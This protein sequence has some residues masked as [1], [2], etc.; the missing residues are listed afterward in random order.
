MDLAA[1]PES[2][3]A[4]FERAQV[5]VGTSL[6]IDADEHLVRGAFFD[7]VEGQARFVAG[8][9]V[10]STA[11]PPIGDLSVAVREVMAL[12]EAQT[13]FPLQPE[14]EHDTVPRAVTL[15]GQPA[16]PIRVAIV[17]TGAH[18][19]TT[20][21]AAVARSTHSIVYVLDAEIRTED[22]VM[23]ATLLENR[24]R[25]F[26]PHVVVLL[27]GDRAQAEWAS[28]VGTL[29]NMLADGTI[30]QMI[31]LA[32]DDFQQ[33]VIQTLGDAP[34][35]TGL[36]P[37]Q[38]ETHE[39]AIALETELSGMYQER[40]R[41]VPNPGLSGNWAYVS[42][43]RAGDLST[44][45][46]ARRLEKSAASVDISSGTTI[47]WSNVHTGGSLCRPDLDLYTHIRGIFGPR[48]EF[49]RALL[50]FELSGEELAN[51]VLNRASRPR[52]VAATPRDELIES[53]LASAIVSHAWEDMANI[54]SEQIEVLI[55]GPA[56]CCDAHPALGVLALLNGVQPTPLGGVVEVHLD[57]DGLLVAAGAVGESAPAVAADVIEHDVLAPVA[58][59]IVVEGE[60]VEGQLA[61]SG[62]LT[63]DDG[64]SVEFEVP[65]GTLRRLDFADGDSGSLW[66]TCEPGFAV[67]GSNPGERM[68]FGQSVPL[69][70]GEVGIIIDARGR[71]L[72]VEGES[73]AISRE[74][75]Q[76]WYAE[77]GI[78]L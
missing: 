72:E 61:V 75:V 62:R 34:N 65:F 49:A 15:T 35:L 71:P 23:S 30:E 8:A 24:A 22:G 16:K 27:E 19:I 44:R 21:L 76:R 7:S 51:W 77:L 63:Y 42:R 57:P 6:V 43:L 36:D 10:V 64:E 32:S 66:L 68:E 73:S 52:V 41:N 28:A 38:Y 46:I 3:D 1:G 25:G 18:P 50:P 31:V 26:R 12:I 59:V 11:G 9:Q 69:R 4:T 56:F 40:A 60:G 2:G 17:P 53:A 67:G 74:M 55:G 78:E 39:V 13:G 70:G 14:D 37:G 20:A 33:H 5:D 58:T 48:F 45:F 54:A 29:G 47:N